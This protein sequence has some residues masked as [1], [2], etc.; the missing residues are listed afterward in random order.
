MEIP[1][2]RWYKVIEKRRSRRRYEEKTLKVNHLR[3]IQT[4]C[5]GFQPF[6]GVRSVLITEPPDNVF[7]GIIG[8]YGTIKGAQAFIAFIGNTKNPAV[9]EQVGYTGEGIVLEAEAAGM[10]TCWVGGLFRR[11]IVDSLIELD[12]NEKV[13]AI[14]PIGYATKKLNLEEKV[15]AGFGIMH[16]RKSLSE[17]VKGLKMRNWPKWMEPTLQAARLAPS[18]VNRQPWTF[19]VDENS[20]TVAVNDKKL[21]RE[22]V[23]SK[24]LCCG[25]AMLHIEVAAKSLGIKGD[26]KFLNPPGVARYTVTQ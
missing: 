22:S 3:R 1:A 5:D 7:K 11:E 8:S 18:A 2:S 9:E 13:Y 20:I 17:L 6:K 26:W 4:F 12:A 15:M 25:I 16:R 14:T 24:R 19:L 10:N 21:R 23:M